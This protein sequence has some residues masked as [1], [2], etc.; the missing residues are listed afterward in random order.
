[1]AN[2][3]AFK[4]KEFRMWC[5]TAGMPVYLEGVDVSAFGNVREREEHE[6]VHIKEDKDDP[7]SACGMRGGV[8]ID[9]ETPT[10]HAVHPM[11]CDKVLNLPSFI[12]EA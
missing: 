2:V 5:N 7:C 8:W 12:R 4:K 9:E 10:S 11:R 3:V 1:M 6:L